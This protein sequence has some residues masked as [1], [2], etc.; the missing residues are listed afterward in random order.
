VRTLLQGDGGSARSE[1]RESHS[2][3]NELENARQKSE[4]A[5]LK[6]EMAEMKNR[7]S[8]AESTEPRMEK[9]KRRISVDSRQRNGTTFRSADMF[10]DIWKKI[11]SMDKELK[12]QQKKS[13]GAAVSC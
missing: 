10:S 13:K 8:S 4:I 9:R 6:S 12:E 5:L 3:R 11:K 7:I 1:T 2:N